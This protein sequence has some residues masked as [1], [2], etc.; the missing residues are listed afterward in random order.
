MK[1]SEIYKNKGFDTFCSCDGRNVV[2]K[3][4]LLPTTNFK[5]K[6][7]VSFV[8]FKVDAY[9]KTISVWH[10]KGAKPEVDTLFYALLADRDVRRLIKQY[11]NTGR[12]YPYKIW[13]RYCQSCCEDWFITIG[14]SIGDFL[15]TDTKKLLHVS[16]EGKLNAG[17]GDNKESSM[18]IGDFAEL[19]V[20]MGLTGNMNRRYLKK[21]SGVR[22]VRPRLAIELTQYQEEV[23]EI[24]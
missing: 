1:M 17:F 22:Y 18:Y 13:N 10:L 15:L 8:G 19:C 2:K 24:L 9:E 11:Q 5:G 6:E 20:T 16:M 14:E 7:A 3:E 4:I 21:L 23:S 12:K